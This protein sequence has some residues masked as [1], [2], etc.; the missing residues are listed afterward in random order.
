MTPA[1]LLST[2]GLGWSL[3]HT[4]EAFVQSQTWPYPVMTS[5]HRVRM[6]TLG[7]F[8]TAEY[9]DRFQTLGY[10]WHVHGPDRSGRSSGRGAGRT[11]RRQHRGPP[12]RANLVHSAAGAFASEEGAP[13]R[14][15]GLRQADD[16]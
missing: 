5:P 1:V 8:W 16:E 9:R 2:P 3:D 4:E 14:R 10:R 7:F 11:D 6:V 15:A 13:S 12:G